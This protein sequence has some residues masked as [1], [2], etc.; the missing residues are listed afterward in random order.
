MAL[1]PLTLRIV[2]YLKDHSDLVSHG[3][4]TEL[5]ERYW[6]TSDIVGAH[7]PDIETWLNEIKAHHGDQIVDDSRIEDKGYQPPGLVDLDQVS[8]SS[9]EGSQPESSTHQ[10]SLPVS[11]ITGDKF[12][13][14]TSPSGQIDSTPHRLVLTLA[15]HAVFYITPSRQMTSPKYSTFDKNTLEQKIISFREA[16]ECISLKVHQ[17]KVSDLAASWKY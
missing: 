12:R 8:D 14:F 17:G 4:Y 5:K 11:Y 15:P 6:G 7:Q 2:D 16:T 13:P 3:I 9:T 1:D 10:S